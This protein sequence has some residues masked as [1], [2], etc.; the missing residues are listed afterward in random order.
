MCAIVNRARDEATG[1]GPESEEHHKKPENRADSL[2]A[3]VFKGDQR[4]GIK[5]SAV[6]QAEDSR[7]QIDGGDGDRR[8]AVRRPADQARGAS[9]IE[10][11]EENRSAAAPPRSLPKALA[12]RRVLKACAASACV[13]PWP[14]R[15]STRC[16]CTPIKL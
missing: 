3:E 8:R 7:D 2:R 1:R 9:S 4:R 10:T 11:R 5:D 6:A 12:P 16:S 13:K 14:R 15:Y